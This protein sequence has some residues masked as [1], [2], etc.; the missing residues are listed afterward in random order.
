[1]AQALLNRVVMIYLAPLL[2]LAYLNNA[3]ASVCGKY[4][5]IPSID[6]AE[7]SRAENRADLWRFF[8]RM[9][10]EHGP[11]FQYRG[12]RDDQGVPAVIHLAGPDLNA[13]VTRQ[14]DAFARTYVASGAHLTLG[15]QSVLILEDDDPA[16][17]RSHDVMA[18]RLSRRNVRS[19]EI[20]KWID[21]L[22]LDSLAA[23]KTKTDLPLKAFT[24]LLTAAVAHR[25]VF[26]LPLPRAVHDAL[27]D[28]SLNAWLG[29][30]PDENSATS[31]RSLFENH[32]RSIAPAI[33]ADSLAAELKRHESAF[34]PGWWMD[35]VTTLYFAGIESTRAVLAF[36]LVEL[37]RRPELQK[38]YLAGTPTDRKHFV[39][40][41]LR[42]HA[43]IS[44]V[45]RRATRDVDVERYRIPAGSLINLDL[46]ATMW[47]A[48]LFDQPLA[49][50]PERFGGR[51]VAPLSHCPFGFGPRVC[52]G[53]FLAAAEVE[54]A[55]LTVLNRYEILPRDAEIPKDNSPAG[56]RTVPDGFSLAIRPR[57]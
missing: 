49:F 15:S 20:A 16:W 57:R 24:D 45:Q 26:G 44:I 13:A 9:H 52:P 1:M 14:G 5:A 25:F 56:P 36:A 41:V 18:P 46:H 55:L 34:A 30:R 21:E 3:A 51:S 6:A 48:S 22:T 35:Q 38:R 53:Q 17:R 54:Q 4:L 32:V 33:A 47:S 27:R 11:A 31:F 50:R 10:D 40:E 37:A 43:V 19:P 23:V 29:K 8:A 39:D 7:L 2:L 12:G 28:E 42:R